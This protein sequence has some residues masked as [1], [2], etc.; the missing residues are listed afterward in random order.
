MFTRF[1]AVAALHV[2]AL[3]FMGIAY[4]NVQ[5]SLAVVDITTQGQQVVASLPNS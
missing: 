2:A 5:D 1:I 3:F 4:S